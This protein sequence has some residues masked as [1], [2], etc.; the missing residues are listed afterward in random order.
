VIAS[1]RM[2]AYTA[3]TNRWTLKAAPRWGTARMGGVVEAG[4]PSELAG[5]HAIWT[6]RDNG[7]GQDE[8]R[9][10]ATDMIWGFP[11]QFN[12]AQ[13]HCDVGRPGLFN[14]FREIARG[15]VQVWP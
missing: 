11:P 8:P 5:T 7:E 2:Y 12:V 15:N 9:D 4:N 6:V 14:V 3:S 10:Q 1:G 13:R